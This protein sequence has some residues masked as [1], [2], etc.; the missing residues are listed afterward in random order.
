VPADRAQKLALAQK[1][2]VRAGC[3]TS[4]TDKEAT[5]AHRKFMKIASE[6]GFKI[7]ELTAGIAAGGAS[8][9]SWTID[10]FMQAA[11]VGKQFFADP[12]VQKTVSA[13]R[14][15][16]SGIAKGLAALKA[17]RAK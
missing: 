6:N 5:A 14:D 9:K 12:D 2:F 8:V 7:D 17:R 10:D 4:P 1:L 15:I 16:G 3:P 13:V 11:V